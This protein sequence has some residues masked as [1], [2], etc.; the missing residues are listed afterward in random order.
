MDAVVLRTLAGFAAFVA[1]LFFAIPAQADEIEVEPAPIVVSE[2][3]PEP[4]PEP[5]PERES[6]VTSE[7][8]LP[9]PSWIP[10]IDIGF[11]TFDYNADTTVRN[12]VNPPAWEGIQH[13][14]E[15]QLMFRIGG[16]LMG[17]AFEDLPGRPRLFVQGG[18]QVRTFSSDT[19][20]QTADPDIEHE[21]ETDVGEYYL[22]GNTQGFDLP[23]TFA[24]QG[25]E[26]LETIQD[27]SWYAAFGV[28]FSVPIADNLLLQIK[29]SLAYS[30]EEIDFSG[31]LATVNEPNPGTDPPDGTPTRTFEV[32]RSTAGGSTEDHSLGIGLE[33]D[34]ALFRNV[35]PVRVSLYAES[36]FMWLVSGSTTTFGDSVASFSVDRDN[37]GIKGG[38][39]VRFSWVGFE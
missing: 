15:R 10:S 1:C 37:L 11:E 2:P 3:E 7:E 13:E 4:K 35:R 12:F 36:R 23:A 20:Y 18:V 24:G 26:V 38:G 22:F 17:P 33:V 25:G 28:A 31:R 19:I 14:A 21:P 29:P 16:E 9:E 32:W 6:V 5:E 27:P 8:D 30:Y 39:G 34:L